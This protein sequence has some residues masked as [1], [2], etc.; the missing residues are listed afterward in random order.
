MSKQELLPNTGRFYPCQSRDNLKSPRTSIGNDSDF[1]RRGV[2]GPWLVEEAVRLTRENC[3]A[4]CERPEPNTYTFAYAYADP[5]SQPSPLNSFMSRLLAR[6]ACLRAFVFLIALDL[7]LK[8][9]FKALLY[10][11]GT[12]RLSC[13]PLPRSPRF[14]SRAGSQHDKYDTL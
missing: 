11:R 5:Y 7:T 4:G 2:G 10:L 3:N 8:V 6:Q 1:A 13:W 9:Q 12:P 14:S